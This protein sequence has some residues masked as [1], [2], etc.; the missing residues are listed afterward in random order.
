ML[1]VGMYLALTNME[2][3]RL[4]VELFVARITLYW[5]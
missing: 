4:R 3:L 5:G 1:V 2:M